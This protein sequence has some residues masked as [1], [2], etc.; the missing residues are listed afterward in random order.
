MEEKQT[1]I[2]KYDLYIEK[3]PN[4]PS[5]DE[6]FR[7]IEALNDNDYLYRD[8][9]SNDFLQN[10]IEKN[11]KRSGYELIYA[12]EIEE[13]MV[14]QF[15]RVYNDSDQQLVKDDTLYC[16]SLMR[17]FGA[18]TRLLDFSYSKYIATYFGLESAYRHIQDQEKIT[19]TLWCID[20]K[21]LLGQLKS[22]PE[23]ISILNKRSTDKYRNDYTFKDLY[24][25]NKYQFVAWENPLKL[26]SRLHV[27]QG[28]FL[29]PGDIKISLMDNLTI[30]FVNSKTKFIKQFSFSF[31]SSDLQD[32]LSKYMRMGITHESLFPGID[33]LWQSM[34]YQFGFY[35]SLHS[36]RQGEYNN[37]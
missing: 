13:E 11:C 22:T 16:L 10:T 21:R 33:G 26:H 23:I 27:Q 20:K 25:S 35:K 4:Y 2:K 3:S 19:C 8:Q 34:D 6:W 5:W 17:H 28:T 15:R 7:A 29:C 30:P 36:W 31:S 32:A 14:R 37:T 24:L 18:P 9:D 12:P 1:K